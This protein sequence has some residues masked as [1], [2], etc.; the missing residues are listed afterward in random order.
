ML[1]SAQ[2]IPQFSVS[3]QADTHRLNAYRQYLATT[4]RKVSITALLIHLTCQALREHP[5]VNARYDDDN[6]IVYDTV[7]MNIAVASPDGLRAPVL[8][9]AERL[10]LP[11]IHERLAALAERARQNRLTPADNA[12]GTISL[13]N[14]GMMGVA[15]FTP[16]INPPQAAILGIG[17]SQ[18]VLL[19]DGN[20]GMRLTEWL[21]LTATADH[22]V[23]DGAGVAAFLNTLRTHIEQID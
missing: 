6:L 13:S 4:G 22:R 19:P 12:E 16:M 8:R 11:E 17:A 5:T 23:L 2:T 18:P 10:G 21:T 20:G 15:H 14:L 7:N 9:S 1:V 3:I